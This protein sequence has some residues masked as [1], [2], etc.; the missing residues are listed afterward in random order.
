MIGQRFGRLVVGQRYTGR[1]KPSKYWHVTCD[2]GTE[3]IVRGSQLTS[4][5]TVSCGCYARERARR[6]RTHGMTGTFEFRSW[7]AMRKR[8]TNPNHKA[9]HRYGGRGIAVCSEW[10]DFATFFADM[11]PCPFPKGSIE[12]VDTDGDYTPANCVWLPKALQSKNRGCVIS[13]RTRLYAMHRE[14]SGLYELV[15]LLYKQL[16]G[17]TEHASDCAANSAP[18]LLPG[19]CNCAGR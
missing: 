4:G 17:T 16:S 12:R 9:Y 3:K 18:A 6:T 7:S 13:S 19:P 2:C 15:G 10:E 5:G 11:G 14:I 1:D 8:C